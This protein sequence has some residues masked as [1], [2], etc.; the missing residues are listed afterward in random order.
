[1]IVVLLFT[2]A[3]VTILLTPGGILEPAT[4]TGGAPEGRFGFTGPM[5]SGQTLLRPSQNCLRC[6]K[7]LGWTYNHVHALLVAGSTAVG[8]SGSVRASRQRMIWESNV[9]M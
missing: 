7:N 2:V 8:V 4:G 5:P 9:P 6:S 3:V 1:M